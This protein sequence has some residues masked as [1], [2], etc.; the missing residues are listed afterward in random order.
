MDCGT[1]QALKSWVE[2]GL[3]PAVKRY[4]GGVRE[5]RVV[6]HYACRPRNNRKGARISEHGK[7]RA[8]DIAA[9]ELNDGKELVVLGD[10]SN[11]REGRILKAAHASACGPSARSWDR[12]PMR[13]IAITSTSTRRATA[14]A[15]TAA[16]PRQRR[17]AP[18][19]SLPQIS[20]PEA[21]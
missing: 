4:G 14:A 2:R 16:D 17:R 20:P 1:A 19:F 9:I 5:L 21:E 10:W 8:V 3:R 11:G 18:V 7:G 13:C 12:R 15:P 6:A